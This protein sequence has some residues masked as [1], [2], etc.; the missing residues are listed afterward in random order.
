M[1]LAM[2]DLI[3]LV[4][5][6]RSRLDTPNGKFP[7]GHLGIISC[8]NIIRIRHVPFYEHHIVVILSG[9]KVMFD[10]GDPLIFAAGSA[11]TV[12]APG[13]FN[14][15]NEPDTNGH[16]YY[17]IGIPFKNSHLERL[18]KVYDIDHIGQPDDIGVLNFRCNEI[19]TASVKHYLE[20]PNE[21]RML[22][23]RL[24][25]ILLVLVEK[26]ARLMSYALNQ[27]NWSQK[28]RSILSADI[29]R[30]WG[31]ADVC[32]HLATSE[33]TLRRNLQLED[34][35]FR[36][37]LYELRLSSALTQLLQTSA[38]IYQVAYDCGY[39]SVSRFSSNFR[40]RFGLPPTEF[41]ASMDEKEQ[42]LA[43]TEQPA[44]P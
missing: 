24:M 11:I 21:P 39:R 4:D 37:L 19:L 5:G 16:P 9:R 22:E 6:L 2:N 34:T 8:G 33:S 20:S 43:V 3:A 38:P 40:K 10:A 28:V 36:E 7:L 29:A 23:H 25:E 14:L 17:A 30:E 18:R 32:R 13:S 12:P 1:G 27:E 44:M 26:D 31:L 15:C 42:I 41:R 35:G